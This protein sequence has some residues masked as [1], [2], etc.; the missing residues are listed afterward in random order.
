MILKTDYRIPGA[1]GPTASHGDRR[2]SLTGTIGAALPL[3]APGL[4]TLETK[5]GRVGARHVRDR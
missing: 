1:E 2:E 3:M 5:H 4:Q